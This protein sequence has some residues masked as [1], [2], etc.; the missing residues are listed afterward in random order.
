MGAK[1][2]IQASK[3]ACQTQTTLQGT[4]AKNIT[5]LKS[6]NNRRGREIAQKN[7][8]RPIFY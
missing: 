6:K 8:K 4:K 7:S 3:K 2:K 5:G 1:K